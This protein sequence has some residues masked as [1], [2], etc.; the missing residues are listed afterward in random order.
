MVI[1]PAEAGTWEERVALLAAFRRE[2]LGGDPSNREIAKA[3]Q[4]APT[5]MGKW[6]SGQRPQQVDQVVTWIGLVRSEASRQGRLDRYAS[7]LLAEPVWRE[8]YDEEGRRRAQLVGQAMQRQRALKAAEGAAPGM[9]VRALDPFVLEVH[10]AIAVDDAAHAGLPALP[11]YVP[12]QHDR[13]L[14]QTVEEVVAGGRALVTLIGGSSSG[15]TRACW[16][17]VQAL[18]DDWR[19][20]HPFFVPREEVLGE[21]RS[22]W[23]K[24]VVWFNEAQRYLLEAEP[25]LARDIT[26]ALHTLLADPTRGPVLVLATLWR[27]RWHTLTRIP[28][29]GESDRHAAQRDL[30]TTVGTSLTVPEV[31]T[32]KD[33]AA[34]ESRAALDAR[35]AQARARALGGAVTQYLAGVPDLLSRYDRV[36]EAARAVLDAAL[37]ARRMG[38]GPDLDQDFLEAAAEDYISRSH[39]NQLPQNWFSQA[40]SYCMEPCRGA[41]AALERIRPRRGEPKPDKPRYKLADYLEQHSLT[42]RGHLCPP[43]SLWEAAVDHAGNIAPAN[44]R[45]L[46]L[47]AEHRGLLH[48]ASRFYAAAAESGEPAAAQYLA[49]LLGQ[50]GRTEEAIY[51]WQRAADSN[52][53]GAVAELVARMLEEAGLT[54]EALDWWQR[55]ADAG[56]PYALDRPGELFEALGRFE[57]AI[58]WWQ[59]AA[60]IAKDEAAMASAY[61]AQ[62]ARLLVK[63]GRVEEAMDRWLRALEADD[64]MGSLMTDLPH[65]LATMGRVEE[66]IDWLRP[67]ADAGDAKALKILR[68]LQ[69]VGD[70]APRDVI[71]KPAKEDRA[72]D[73]VPERQTTNVT[74]APLAARQAAARLLEEGRVTEE[75]IDRLHRAGAAGNHHALELGS[76]VLCLTGRVDEAIRW[77]QHAAEERDSPGTS[78]T[79]AARYAA[80]RTAKLMYETGRAEEAIRWLQSRAET[81]DVDAAQEATRMLMEASQTTQALNW[82]KDC[83]AAGQPYALAVSVQLLADVGR[84]D[85]SKELQQYG[86][87]PDGA[88]A[89]PWTAIPEIA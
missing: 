5:T 49:S 88:V 75:S 44:L 9:P 68:Q 13:D 8:L 77:W 24:T 64:F 15:K 12:R 38:H 82:L 7:G 6:W 47:A 3:A 40:L 73:A 71:Q 55:A 81:G 42:T 34:L 1:D 50:A 89:K 41:I 57:E 65:E 21:L 78:Y 20:W 61:I 4:V 58:C 18:P 69:H 11:L 56:N 74:D 25:S 43:A 87:K 83:A 33:L 36:P 59:R 52:H 39:W 37:D 19:L 60:D 79:S 76:A 26:A 53:S 29:S 45:A 35:L 27:E 2:Q 66:A 16:E 86:W 63:T 23:P 62:G 84:T 22:L 32:D 51:W 30:L 48:V 46:G 31:F 54:E 10:R 17:A 14:A 72:E 85:E 28:E 80:K 70:N 67:R